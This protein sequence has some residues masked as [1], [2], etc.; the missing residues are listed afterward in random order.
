MVRSV[1][2]SLMRRWKTM[3]KVKQISHFGVSTSPGK[4]REPVYQCFT[5]DFSLHLAFGSTFMVCVVQVSGVR[6]QKAGTGGSFT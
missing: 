6:C 1:I 5:V 3:T 4:A 2:I